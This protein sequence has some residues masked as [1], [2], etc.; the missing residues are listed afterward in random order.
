MKAISTPGGGGVENGLGGGGKRLPGGVQKASKMSTGGGGGSKR[1]PGGVENR[2]GGDD[3]YERFLAGE[4]SAFVATDEDDG[5]VRGSAI[6]MA[7]AEMEEED[8]EEE[9]EEEEEDV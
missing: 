1:A 5:D 4:I 9:E 7:L 6:A 2:F 3:F 8:E